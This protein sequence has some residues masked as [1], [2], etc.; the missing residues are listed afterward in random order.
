MHHSGA[1]R[2]EAVSQP[3]YGVPNPSSLCLASLMSANAYLPKG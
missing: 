3:S 1:A 2:L